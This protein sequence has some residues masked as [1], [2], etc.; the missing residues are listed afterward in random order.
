MDARQKATYEPVRAQSMLGQPFSA[1]AE[2]A[3]LE[4]G[5]KANVI[6]E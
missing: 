3:V 4:S 6:K 2:T 5:F 1:P